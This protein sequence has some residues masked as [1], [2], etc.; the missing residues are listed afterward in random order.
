MATQPHYARGPSLLRAATPADFH[1]SGRPERPPETVGLCLCCL[2]P[3]CGGAR[4]SHE[5]G[6]KP[7]APGPGKILEILRS[8][9]DFRDAITTYQV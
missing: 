9:E 6:A 7:D 1:A 2:V 5:A 4:L 8:V 3:W